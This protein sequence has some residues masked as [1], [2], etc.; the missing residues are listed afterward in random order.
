MSMRDP[1]DG[2][3]TLPVPL[4]AHGE[5]DPDAL[6]R[7]VTLRDICVNEIQSR[8]L[9][10]RCTRKAVLDAAQAAPGVH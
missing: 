7:L 9:L 1:R 3:P 10:T 5:L 6:E 2:T 4:P 8:L